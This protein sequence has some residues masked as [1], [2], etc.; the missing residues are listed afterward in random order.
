MGLR[1]VRFLLAGGADMNKQ[2]WL[3]DRTPLMLAANS[4]D[5]EMIKV[6]LNR[7]ADTCRTVKY[8]DNETTQRIGRKEA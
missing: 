6:L 3:S 1:V 5:T 4:G 7:G 2:N 8:S